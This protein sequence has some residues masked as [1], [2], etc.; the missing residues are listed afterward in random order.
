MI[1]IFFLVLLVFWFDILLSQESLETDQFKSFSILSFQKDFSYS[2]E[3]KVIT[4][5]T[6][7]EKEVD[8]KLMP[9]ISHYYPVFDGG[10]DT[11]SPIII[12][13][14]IESQSMEEISS[15]IR[16]QAKSKYNS[17]NVEDLIICTNSEVKYKI[18]KGSINRFITYL[19]AIEG[20]DE[21]T[22]EMFMNYL[23]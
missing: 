1:K 16:N 15:V 4:I 20:I 22:K 17:E 18:N 11:L 19:V 21:Q 8:H 5:F 6:T 10:S 23:K 14:Q 2:S 9:C 13:V 7:L 3:R 12:T